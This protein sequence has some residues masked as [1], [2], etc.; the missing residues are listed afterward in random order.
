MPIRTKQTD[1]RAPIYLSLHPHDLIVE[2][3]R[4]RFTL[5]SETRFSYPTKDNPHQPN[6]AKA[7]IFDDGLCCVRAIKKKER[8]RKI[9][10][11]ASRITRQTVFCRRVKIRQLL[12]NCH[13]YLAIS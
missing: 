11:N 12:Q 10:V 1:T 4:Q 6:L 3:N 2:M 7:V 13:L 9:R 5:Q 8:D